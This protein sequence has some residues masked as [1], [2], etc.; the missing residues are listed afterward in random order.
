[1][2]IKGEELRENR[3]FVREESGG[4]DERG[5]LYSAWEYIVMSNISNGRNMQTILPSPTQTS[6]PIIRLKDRLIDFG[7]TQIEV[8]FILYSHCSRINKMS[9]LQAGTSQ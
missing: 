6:F 5:E 1:M 4:A 3:E 9:D 7:R 2:E 8:R